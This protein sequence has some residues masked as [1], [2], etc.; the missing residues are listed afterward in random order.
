MNSKD[1]PKVKEFDLQGLVSENNNLKVLINS[2]RSDAALEIQ[3]LKAQNKEYCEILKNIQEKTNKHF[4]EYQQSWEKK[5]FL[6]ETKTKKI[7]VE[8]EKTQ[9]LLEESHKT[10]RENELSKFKDAE[11]NK[12]IVE[13]FKKIGQ[14]IT[15][16]KEKYAISEERVNDLLAKN[17]FLYG[18]LQKYK[19]NAEVAELKLEKYLDEFQKQVI[20]LENEYNKA[21]NTAQSVQRQSDTKQQKIDQL[22]GEI[23][24]YKEKLDKIQ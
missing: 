22:Q 17:E 15:K 11:K 7:E 12:V 5:Y 20:V 18:E 10:S 6:L 9:K 3:V 23:Y 16:W 13:D 8:L 4:L 24:E 1:F 19:H 21:N 14:E 2:V